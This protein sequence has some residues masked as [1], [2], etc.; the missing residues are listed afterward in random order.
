MTDG[1]LITSS[2][3]GS[4]SLWRE[5][6]EV[7]SSQGDENRWVCEYS[8]TA[9]GSIYA[10]C[11]LDGRVVSAGDGRKIVMWGAELDWRI[12]KPLEEDQPGG[13]VWS[14]EVCKGRLVSGLMDG[15]IRV[16]T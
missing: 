15:T 5:H 1:A 16:W 4:I 3:N 14:L 2:V 6:S 13:G 7:S 10:L 8:A 11:M 9:D 12:E